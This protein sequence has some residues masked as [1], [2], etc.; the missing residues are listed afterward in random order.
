MRFLLLLLFCVSLG[1]GA[2][3]FP[4]SYYDMKPTLKKQVAFFEYLYPRIVAANEKILAERTIVQELQKKETLTDKDV[5]ALESL[6]SKYGVKDHKDFKK[7]LQK[8][9]IIPPSMALAQAAVESG[10]GMSRFVKL[11]NNLF[12]HWTYG[13]VGIKPLRRDPGATHLVRI[14]DSLEDSIAA[15]MLN[16]NKG[17][18]YYNFR[19]L[20]ETQRAKGENP[21]GMA[22]SQTM[23]NYS[24]IGEKYLRILKRMIRSNK[25]ENYDKKYYE[26]RTK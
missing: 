21:N 14:F 16:L 18:A 19:K 10:W 20:R 12:G 15:Y 6:A 7:L 3:G 22:L 17:R 23:I 9:D 2:N 4:K 13:K 11:G 26:N 25:L 1:L 5:K 24:G 8:I